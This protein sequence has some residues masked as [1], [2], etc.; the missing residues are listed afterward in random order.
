MS[1]GPAAWAHRAAVG[2]P[3]WRGGSGGGGSS[4]WGGTWRARAEVSGTPSGGL[5]AG[6]ALS[7]ALCLLVSCLEYK[8]LFDG[9]ENL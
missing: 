7:T 9:S 2:W 4:G 8:H 5:R 1:G 3:R 6:L